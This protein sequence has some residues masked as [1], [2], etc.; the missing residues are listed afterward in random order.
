VFV[1]ERVSGILLEKPFAT[2]AIPAV[3]I[4]DGSR[5]EMC[6]LSHKRRLCGNTVSVVLT[7]QVFE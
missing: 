2:L 3:S 1:S 7:S 5:F 4:N 6:C